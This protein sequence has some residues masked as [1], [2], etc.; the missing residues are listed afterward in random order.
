MCIVHCLHSL[1]KSESSGAGENIAQLTTIRVQYTVVVTSGLFATLVEFGAGTT[2]LA[3]TPSIFV[4]GNLLQELGSGLTP[5]EMVLVRNEVRQTVRLPL[6]C[7][8]KSGQLKRRLVDQNACDAHR[9]RRYFRKIN[10]RRDQEL[11]QLPRAH[12]QCAPHLRHKCAPGAHL[13]VLEDKKP[14]NAGK[15]NKENNRRKHTNLFYREALKTYQ[16]Y[17]LAEFLHRGVDKLAY[18]NRGVLHKRLLQK[19]ALAQIAVHFALDGFRD[20]K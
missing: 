14:R 6:R 20:R 1:I 15:R 19:H 4:L 3:L 13:R 12:V 11:L 17:L 18:G 10:T 9:L 16:F 8:R 2:A 5:F 7:A